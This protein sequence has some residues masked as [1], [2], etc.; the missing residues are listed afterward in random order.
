MKPINAPA[1]VKFITAFILILAG[2]Q[3]FSFFLEISGQ[4]GFS[5][6]IANTA[7]LA[8]ALIGFILARMNFFS[9]KTT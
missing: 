1:T 6:P 2:V 8:G 4:Q 7:H 5:L 9:W 3:M